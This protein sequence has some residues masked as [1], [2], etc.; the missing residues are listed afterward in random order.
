[1]VGQHKK[2]GVIFL[3]YIALSIIVSFIANA[4]LFSAIWLEDK[5]LPA[6]G[7]MLSAIFV[8]LFGMVVYLA[9]IFLTV[10]VFHKKFAICKA[11]LDKSLSARLL[12]VFYLFYLL[13]VSFLSYALFYIIEILSNIGSFFLDP[14]QT[15]IAI[16]ALTSITAAYLLSRMDLNRLHIHGV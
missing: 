12:W 6:L 13:F 9:L 15:K 11:N 5:I 4:T 2:M 14:V 7:T 16:L 8:T 10:R 1:M 3:T